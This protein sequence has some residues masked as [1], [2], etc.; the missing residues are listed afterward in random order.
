MRVGLLRA[1]GTEYLN[2]KPLRDSDWPR[3]LAFNKG[4]ELASQWKPI[5]VVEARNGARSLPPSDFPLLAPNVPV[6]S[7][8]AVTRLHDCLV[9]CGELLSLS[10]N[11]HEYH[12]FN[13]M[14]TVDCLD[15]ERSTITRY[16]SGGIMDIE[17]YHFVPNKLA[18]IE[19]FRLPNYSATVF[20]TDIFA[21]RVRQHGLTGVRIPVVWDS[22]RS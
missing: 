4:Q 19:M 12:A 5:T 2:L 18:G 16:P 10:F 6:F 20:V 13:C 22:E 14:K 3:I 15:F 17:R 11:T 8:Q 21:R 7:Q 1:E 9:E